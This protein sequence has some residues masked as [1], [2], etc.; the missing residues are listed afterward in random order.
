M[1]EATA[2]PMSALPAVIALI[3]IVHIAEALGAS[4]VKV[5]VTT[6]CHCV[7]PGLVETTHNV[8]GSAT[9]ANTDL[10]VAGPL[11]WIVMVQ[12]PDEPILSEVG[13]ARLLDRSARIEGGGGVVTVTANGPAVA[14]GLTPLE[15]ITL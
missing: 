1:F 9:A 2:A 3:M 4:E 10:A 6:P 14:L 13:Q 15:A 8:G 7:Q 11:L 12:L 5:S